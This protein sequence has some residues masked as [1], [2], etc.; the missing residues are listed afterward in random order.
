M[1]ISAKIT[2][3]SAGGNT[4]PFDLYSNP[5]SPTSHGTLFASGIT[6]NDLLAGYTSDVVPNSTTTIRCKS[7]NVTCTNYQDFALVLPSPTP[8]PTSTPP[9]TTPTST[10]LTPIYSFKLGT[11]TTSTEACN[12][13]D[14]PL[15]VNYYSYDSVLDNG[16]ILYKFNGYPLETLADNGYYANSDH[17][18]FLVSGVIVGYTPCTYTPTPTPTPTRHGLGF[19]IYTG[20][21]YSSSTNACASDYA[22]TYTGLTTCYLGPDDE[23]PV[24]GLFFYKDL[25]LDPQN[26]FFGDSNY[27]I[28]KRSMPTLAV[29]AV[30]IGGTGEITDVVTC[31]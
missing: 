21:T 9:S 11:G 12:D 20:T 19:A 14:P 17:S 5:S 13:Y 23:V 8:T 7:N 22:H 18:F 29:Y 28:V 16:S 26:V 10:P 27:Y 31:P 25:Y 15:N 24:N 6:K 2:L 3:T 4:G 1:S 30:R